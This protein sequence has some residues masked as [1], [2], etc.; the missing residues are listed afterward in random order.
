MKVKTLLAFTTMTAGGVLTGAPVVAH[1]ATVTVKAGDTLSQIAAA[2]HT[3]V[4]KLQQLNHVN[5]YKLQIGSK[6]NLPTQNDYQ[7]VVVK[8]GDTL[9][10]LAQEYGTSV[11]ALQQLNNLSGTTIYVG[12]VLKVSGNTPANTYVAPKASVKPASASVANSVASAAVKAVKVASATPVSAAKAVVSVAPSMAP[13]AVHVVSQQVT[14]SIASVA[15]KAI[16][17]QAPKSVAKS[18]APSAV[19]QQKIVATKPVSVAKPVASVAPQRQTT[20]YSNNNYVAHRSMAAQTNTVHQSAPVQQAAQQTTK[21]TT[22]TGSAAAAANA[23]AQAESGGSYTA[24]N[25]R[26]YGKYQLDIS[27]LH[28]DLSPANQDRVFQQYCNQ[29]YGSVQNALAFRE[30]HGWY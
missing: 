18:V 6:L 24:R 27:Y 2:N 17:Q 4:A 3:S 22:F 8:A 29:R 10:T 11:S 16:S 19:S 12:Q 15:P 30:A 7:T 13:K 25:G 5:P 9:S 21:T 26:Y 1:A 28:G 23:I 14:K 20:N